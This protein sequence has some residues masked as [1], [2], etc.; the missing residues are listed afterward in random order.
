MFKKLLST[1]NIEEKTKLYT[2]L[3]FMLAGLSRLVELTA[4][5]VLASGLGDKLAS[6]F[7]KLFSE[8]P[9]DFFLLAPMVLFFTLVVSICPAVRSNLRDASGL[10]TRSLK[11]KFFLVLPYWIFG[12]FYLWL[13]SWILL[14]S[15]REGQLLLWTFSLAASLW[16]LVILEAISKYLSI[17]SKLREISGEEIPEGLSGFFDRWSKEQKGKLLVVQSFGPGLTMPSYQGPDLIVTEK[18]L[19]AFQPESLKA[20]LIMAMVSQML[21]LKRNFLVLRLVSLTMAVPVSMMLLYSL[22]FLI[23]YPVMIRLSQIAIVWMGC[24]FSYHISTL[25]LNIISRILHQRLNLATISILGQVMPLVK[26]IETMSRYNLMPKKTPWWKL[27]CSPYP[28]PKE[29]IRTLM[30]DLGDLSGKGSKKD[31]ANPGSSNNSADKTNPKAKVT[32]S[33]ADDL[34]DSEFSDLPKKDRNLS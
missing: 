10:D 26:A 6:L 25:V 19:A 30:N 12:F 22:G 21:K 3:D 4:L 7:S 14:T 34:L 29:Q 24:W 5:L 9:V 28:G 15:M 18:A 1:A 20:G 16:V 27:I 17:K 13:V 23:G 2:L 11:T 32:D 33:L 31:S 8:K